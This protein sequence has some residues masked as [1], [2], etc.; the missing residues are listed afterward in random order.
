MARGRYFPCNYHYCR[1]NKYFK[2]FY[3]Q[4]KESEPCLAAG[5]GPPCVARG[6]PDSRARHVLP[7][8]G[9]REV[10]WPKSRTK[11]HKVCRLSSSQDTVLVL[12]AE[13]RLRQLQPCLPPLRLQVNTYLGR[14]WVAGAVPGLSRKPG[15]CAQAPRV[16]GCEEGDGGA[17]RGCVCWGRGPGCVWVCV[18]GVAPGVCVWVCVGAWPPRGMC[19]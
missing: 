6:L 17:A 9:A 14:R 4:G 8:H 7:C 19:V 3:L 1:N 2:S 18:G 12:F 15:E 5:L 13:T 11:S 16:G 10:K